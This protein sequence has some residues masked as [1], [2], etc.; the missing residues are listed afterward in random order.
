MV[1]LESFEPV[2]ENRIGIALP[3][4]DFSPCGGE[5][6]GRDAFEQSLTQ[7]FPETAAPDFSGA[8]ASQPGSMISARGRECCGDPFAFMRDG[9]DYRRSPS[10]GTM[11]EIEITLQLVLQ[12]L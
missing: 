1:I 11:R 9:V 3:L 2:M 4:G 8:F 10:V 7:H 12:F 5:I 6:F